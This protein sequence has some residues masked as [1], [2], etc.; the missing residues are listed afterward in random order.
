MQKG[1]GDSLVLIASKGQGV[2]RL[3]RAMQVLAGWR[4]VT[5]ALSTSEAR[6]GRGA[7]T[8]CLRRQTSY[9]SSG[10]RN[11]SNSKLM[12]NDMHQ[13]TIDGAKRC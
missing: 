12:A 7:T 2:S 5:L 11:D 13:L 10:P 8:S 6:R 4:N 9:S 1:G 3:L